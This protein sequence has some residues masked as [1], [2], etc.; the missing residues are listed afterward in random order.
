MIRTLTFL[1]GNTPNMLING[2]LFTNVD[3]DKIPELL[4]GAK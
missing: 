4:G 2:E 3:L 1:P